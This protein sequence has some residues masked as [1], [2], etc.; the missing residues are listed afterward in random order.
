MEEGLRSLGNVGIFFG[1]MFA[2]VGIPVPLPL[3]LGLVYAA[4]QGYG[5]TLVP[6]GFLVFGGSYLG[7]VIGYLV[8][9]HGGRP[10]VNHLLGGKQ[11]K[12]RAFARI[13]DLYNRYGIYSLIFFRWI[14]SGK[15]QIIWLCGSCRLDAGRF[16][17]G[18]VLVE[19]PWAIFWV[20]LVFSFSDYI[21]HLM[22][23]Y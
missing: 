19:L 23:P 17:A 20:Y 3:L 14:S 15:A 21:R 10:L 5:L 8:F 12:L 22:V 1:F 18:L 6:A 13:E 2:S 9:K 7:D 11:S 16:L 4:K